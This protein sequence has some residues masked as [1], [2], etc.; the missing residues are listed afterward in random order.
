MRKALVTGV[1]GFIGSHLAER[2]VREGFEV[3]GVDSFEDYYP[4]WI[5]KKNIESLLKCKNFTFFEKNILSED[6]FNL[7]QLKSVD[8]IF[9]QAAQAGVRKS[10]GKDFEVY[11]KNNILATQKLLEF[12]KEKGVGKFIYASS[13]S[14]YGEVKSLPFK[15]NSP[16]KPFSP[17]GVSKLAGENLC[18][19]YFKNFGVPTVSLRYF[20]VYGPR[21][22]PDM[23]FHK[24]IKGIIF[25]EEIEIYGDGSQTRD[26][27][28]VDDVVEANI[29][30]LD[31]PP[32]EI[33]NI[34]GGERINL[35]DALRLIE[36][37][38]GKKAKVKKKD[39]QKGDLQDTLADIKKAKKILNYRPKVKIEGGLEKEILWIKEIYKK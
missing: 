26:F 11:T 35:I 22:R 17:Y 34:G 6:F 27:T 1:A 15:E 18:Y 30:S 4:R 32:G 23:A 19:L 36:K 16:A 29:L 12:A 8:Y 2:L 21:Q 7:P 37:L 14:V 28:Y 3:V 33:F 13:S 10:W 31:S 24:F 9:H 25:D 39:S 20:T 5:K 38:L